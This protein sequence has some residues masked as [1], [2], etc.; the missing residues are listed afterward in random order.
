M[1]EEAK[2]AAPRGAIRMAAINGMVETMRYKGQILARS[3]KFDS[4]IMDS[5][6]VGFAIGILLAV[7]LILAPVVLLR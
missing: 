5:G 4:S 1:A 7:I 3:N 2:P 6:I